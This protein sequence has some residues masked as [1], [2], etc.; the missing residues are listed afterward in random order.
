MTGLKDYV[1]ESARVVKKDDAQVRYQTN[2]ALKNT[3]L[4]RK[5]KKDDGSLFRT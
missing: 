3:L 5:S 1:K 2:S 4:M